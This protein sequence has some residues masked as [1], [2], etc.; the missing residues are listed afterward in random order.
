MTSAVLLRTRGK[1]VTTSYRRMQ[2]QYWA[3]R[4]AGWTRI[5]CVI[6][7]CD[8]VV[9]AMKYHF[10]TYDEW[11]MAVTTVLGLAAWFIDR[12]TRQWRYDLWI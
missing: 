10:P 1:E 7:L 5:V 2:W 12:H 8:E 9:V 3:N 4:A 6:A 11:A